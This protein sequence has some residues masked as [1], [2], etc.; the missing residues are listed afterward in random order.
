MGMMILGMVFVSLAAFTKVNRKAVGTSSKTSQAYY[1]GTT[2]TEGIKTWYA[3][4][5]LKTGGKIR[6]DTLFDYLGNASTPTK[7]TVKSGFLYVRNGTTYHAKFTFKR[8][9]DVKD[10]LIHA[11]GRIVWDSTSPTSDKNVYTWGVLLGQPLR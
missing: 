10:S 6:Y 4:T 8:I 3:D 1:V 11:Q 2:W 7:D 5:T 9:G